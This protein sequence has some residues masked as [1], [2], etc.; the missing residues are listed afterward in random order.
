MQSR[1]T[2]VLTTHSMEEAD[3]LC[4]RIAILTNQGIQCVGSQL[5]LKNKFGRGFLLSLKP[6]PNV[7]MSATEF[8]QTHLHP[9]LVHVENRLDQA[10]FRVDRARVR[11]SSLLQQ[12]SDEVRL[13]RIEKWSIIPASLDDVFMRLCLQQERDLTSTVVSGTKRNPVVARKSSVMTP[14]L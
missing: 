12:I 1:M 6:N 5:H 2:I 14:L 13:G 9:S 10:I 3:T 7:N 4:S 8:A 11:V